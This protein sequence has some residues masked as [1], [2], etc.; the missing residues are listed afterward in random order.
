[1]Y[2]IMKS[3]QRC[4]DLRFNLNLNKLTSINRW[5]PS[6]FLISSAKYLQVKSHLESESGRITVKC[7]EGYRADTQTDNSPE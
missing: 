4:K 5:K 6:L 1:M 2:A 7:K 3:T